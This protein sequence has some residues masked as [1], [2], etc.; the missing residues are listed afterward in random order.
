MNNNLL[1]ISI[2]SIFFAVLLFNPNL[3]PNVW[4]SYEYINTGKSIAQGEG[5]IQSWNPD[6]P[7]H[8]RSIGYPLILSLLIYF[9]DNLIF[10]KILSLLCY[11][12]NFILVYFMF[13]KIF[14]L[15]NIIT[16]IFSLI[17]SLNQIT[18]TLSH[19]IL[20]DT[21]YLLMQL[22]SLTLASKYVY[23]NRDMSI[24]AVLIP[25]FMFISWQIRSIGLAIILSTFFYFI[26]QKQYKKSL[27]MSVFLIPLLL[28]IFFYN[29]GSGGVLDNYNLLSSL[30]NTIIK[31]QSFIQLIYDGFTDY[32]YMIPRSLFGFFYDTMGHFNLH[33]MA[34]FNILSFIISL[35]VM[36]LIILGYIQLM[37]SQ[38]L[39]GY[40][41]AIYIAVLIVFPWN[42][43]RAIFPIF[44]F[45]LIYFYYGLKLIIEQLS[46]IVSI[47]K[48]NVIIIGVCIAILFFSTG[49]KFYRAFVKNEN[50]L[51][52]Y[53]NG[54][55]TYPIEWQNYFMG[56]FWLKT[57]IPNNSVVMTRDSSLCFLI[58]GKKSV[59]IEDS[60]NVND[61]KNLLNIQNVDY[62]I[63]NSYYK[64]THEKFLFE[65]IKKN[66]NK[67]LEV[68]NINN[69]SIR[70]FKVV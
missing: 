39:Y 46:A 55:S 15:P 58:T 43:E 25:F 64:N 34:Y 65:V 62:V 27:L 17:F 8:W 14:R 9:S 16:L 63:T 18:L 33:K 7:R 12:G 3:R 1:F 49:E 24:H 32:F 57:N 68:Y 42:F 47:E 13:S 50:I 28:F 54:I 61:V 56:L 10:L 66:P 69:N 60:K 70:I 38:N 20:S 36:I 5:Y 4:D 45:L 51:S 53:K 67:F 40:F 21:P 31:P 29:G 11:I 22:L 41:V 30:K 52:L 26:T 35:M 48:N 59:S 2:I 44:P 19:S 37:P 6:E 23:H